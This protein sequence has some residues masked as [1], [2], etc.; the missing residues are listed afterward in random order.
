MSKTTNKSLEKD[1]KSI[2]QN[3]DKTFDK[4]ENEHK[5]ENNNTINLSFIM[6]EKAK[7]LII[8]FSLYTE[9]LLSLRQ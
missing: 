1:V 7:I 6:I 3:L 9:N 2:L 8:S 5:T 4:D